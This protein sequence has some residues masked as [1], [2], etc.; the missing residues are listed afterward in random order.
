LKYYNGYKAFVASKK[1]KMKSTSLSVDDLTLPKHVSRGLDKAGGFRK[2]AESLPSDQ[3]LAKDAN[4]HNALSDV[5][6]LKILWA[7]DSSELCPC[8][9]KRI[10]RISDS[11]LS[12]HL[13][14]LEK[15]GLIRARR[16]RSW[17]IYIITQSGRS[18]V[19]ECRRR[20]G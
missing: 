15:A 8:V 16:T 14:V 1:I 7:L 5:I 13:N 4:H 6:R 2:L 20:T 17:R 19:S 11:K 9:L 18:A 3:A 12:Y 10:T